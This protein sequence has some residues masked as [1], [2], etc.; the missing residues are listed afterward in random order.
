MLHRRGTLLLL[1]PVVYA[2]VIV[3]TR[4]LSIGAVHLDR[5]LALQ[6]V[7]VPAVQMAA[8]AA[9]FAIVDRRRR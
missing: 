7:A 6:L 3:A 1:V 2:T 9:V 8:L 4:L 5:V